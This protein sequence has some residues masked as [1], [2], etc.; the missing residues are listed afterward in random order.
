M[1]FIITY[2]FAIV[3]SGSNENLSMVDGNSRGSNL[4]N[5][6]RDCLL[7]TATGR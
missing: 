2:V 3:S 4:T 7:I 6:L 5:L 1:L